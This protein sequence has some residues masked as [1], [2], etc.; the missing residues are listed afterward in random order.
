MDFLT[1]QFQDNPPP[2]EVNS[3]DLS[4]QNMRSNQKNFGVMEN[5]VKHLENILNN[6]VDIS[7][8]HG[9]VAVPNPEPYA[10][11]GGKAI[12]L[13][14]K[15]SVLEHSF[16]FDVH[17]LNSDGSVLMQQIVTQMNRNAYNGLT[18]DF[19]RNILRTHGLVDDADDDY[20]RNPTIPIF[21]WGIRSS[22]TKHVSSLFIRLQLN[23]VK[24]PEGRYWTN[25]P[26][27][28]ND[29]LHVHR[30]Q[31][32]FPFADFMDERTLKYG[33]MVGPTLTDNLIAH[34]A[35]L[36]YA[37]PAYII[38]SLYCYV[39]YG[40]QKFEKNYHKFIQILNVENY[41]CFVKQYKLLSEEVL[42][43]LLNQMPRESMSQAQPLLTRNEVMKQRAYIQNPIGVREVNIFDPRGNIITNLE[44]IYWHVMSPCRFAYD[45]TV[46]FNYDKFFDTT[47]LIDNKPITHEYI[48][49]MLDAYL[50]L[51]LRMDTH[52]FIYDYT[53]DS[54]WVNLPLQIRYH[55]RRP[56]NFNFQETCNSPSLGISRSINHRI[57]PQ[58]EDLYFDVYNQISHLIRRINQEIVAVQ[59]KSILQPYFTVYRF[60]AYFFYTDHE[61]PHR[62]YD[63]QSVKRYDIMYVPH[64]QSTSF[65]TGCATSHF[66]AHSGVMFKITINRD[67]QNWVL[68]NRYSVFP[69]QCE[70]LINKN[71]YLFVT[72]IYPSTIRTRAHVVKDVTVIE[73]QLHDTYES[74]S[75]VR[76]VGMPTGGG[77]RT[78]RNKTK[79]KKI[80]CMYVY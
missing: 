13:Y 28:Y 52:R 38:F 78:M 42:L 18:K 41:S 60:V 57:N 64:F 59:L 72:D 11:V 19:I 58:N 34:I 76:P 48:G 12:N 32:M 40:G 9:L 63:P 23:L 1:S 46:E 31:I 70:L 24:E 16:D 66:I 67:S 21:F 33:I 43:I 25:I 7:F 35:G 15:S 30:T 75:S 71:I 61:T 22:P 56:I 36:R 69:D 4:I 62:I 44:A 49:G 3:I 10:I 26:S 20:Y 5:V 77:R 51:L 45:E 17:V 55:G 47:L 6:I 37:N 65:A 54:N 39:L 8:T 29:H 53:C 27:T 74:A 2:V 80:K 73:C 14:I 79:N 50:N 68:L